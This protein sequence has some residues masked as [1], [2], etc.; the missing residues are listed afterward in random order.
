MSERIVLAIALPSPVTKPRWS[1]RSLNWSP[2]CAS[3][4][5]ASV[6]N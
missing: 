5:D 6:T 4:P 3:G 2:S 1:R